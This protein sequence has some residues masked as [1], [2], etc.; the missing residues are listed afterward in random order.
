[1]AGGLD[2][3]YIPQSADF[4]EGNLRDYAGGSGI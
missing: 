4:L 1:M 3:S 2:I